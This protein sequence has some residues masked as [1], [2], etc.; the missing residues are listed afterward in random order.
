MKTP[1]FVA[2]VEK[3]RDAQKAFYAAE[4]GSRKRTDLQHSAKVLEMEVD[5]AIK[6]LK[7]PELFS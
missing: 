3:M 7:E 1:E 4:Y 6:K 5:Q 2:L